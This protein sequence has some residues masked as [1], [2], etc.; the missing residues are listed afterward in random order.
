MTPSRLALILAAASLAVSVPLA[1][2]QF[3]PGPGGGMNQP[4]RKVVKDF[5]KDGN[6]R[7]NTE[8]RK[9]A[10]EFLATQPTGGPGGGRGGRGGGGGGRGGGMG[11]T[12]QVGPTITPAQVKPA[13]TPLYD[14]ATL[15]T[16][17]LTFEN[18]DWE[19]ELE[20]FHNTD[21]EVPATMVVDG[22]TYKEVGLHFR[23]ASSYSMVP[24]GF[25][26]SLNVTV[27]FADEKQELYGYRT[28]NLNNANGD[29][30]LMRAVVYETISRNY[31]PTSAANLVRVV[32]N[33]EYWGVYTNVAQFNKDFLR[34]HFKTTE[35]ARWKVP[36]SPG[37]RGGLEYLGEDVAAYKRLYEIKTKDTP[38]MWAAFIRLTKVL[39]QTPADQ[40][41]AAL[42][43]I[44]D[45]DGA[46]KF[47]AV[48]NALVNSDG[49]WTRASDYSLYLDAKGRFHIIPHDINEAMLSG[50]GRGGG[51]G[52]PMG[53]PPGM[54][55]GMP[56]E[57]QGRQGGRGGMGGGRGGPGGGGPTLDPLVA[58][59]DSSKPLIS[60]LLAVPKFREQYLGY[61]RDIATKWLDWNVLG[62]VVEKHHALIKADVY[63]DV[64]KLSTNDAFDGSIA[65]LKQFVDA[66]RQYLLAAQR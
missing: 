56:P 21:V 58:V 46:L 62:P 53:P 42:S 16:I 19:T 51:P 61:V 9:A 32:I 35:G 14:Q 65:G 12:P 55:G 15:R 18:A 54:A 48:E 8:E 66:R 45:I 49:Y 7:L 34:D 1:Q 20:A 44:L 59:N 22:K 40:L 27:D 6:G 28:L 31:I 5:D 3:G 52:G 41:E 47:L 43:P 25:K 36:G 37:G 4:E 60:K 30:S 26:R 24:R 10:R 63:T 50:G 64:K 38:E 57:M 17:F 23:G 29:P 2:P 39:N 33:G 11:G 13:T